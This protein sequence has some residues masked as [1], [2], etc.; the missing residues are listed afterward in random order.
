MASSI[1]NQSGHN[2]DILLN[3]TLISDQL[4]S[5]IR[6]TKGSLI[7]FE[8]IISPATNSDNGYVRNLLTYKTYY[9]RNL[10]IFSIRAN[11]P[12]F[13]LKEIYYIKKVYI[14]YIYNFLI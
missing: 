9:K 12:L 8:N 1:Q 14:N 7:Q 5:F 11:T 10:N 4:N 6:P 2:A 13:A 3:N